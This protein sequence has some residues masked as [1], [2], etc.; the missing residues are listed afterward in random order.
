MT[1]R[2]KTRSLALAVACSALLLC[3]GLTSCSAR[4]GW[5]LVLWTAPAGPLAAGTIV[6]VY[7]KSNIEKLYVVGIPGSSKK[8]ELPLWQVELFPS[9]GKAAARL[10]ELGPNTSLYMVA[11]RDGLPIREDSTN[12]SRRVYRLREGQ[13]VK[14]LAKVTGEEV[15]TGGQVLPGDWYLVMADDGT[16]G[17]VFSYA[18]RI[19]DETKEGPPAVASSQD[20]ASA[21]VDLIFG[22]SWRPEYFQEMLDDQRVDLD[23]FSL[24]Y[25][26]FTDAVRHQIRI[27]LPT[28]SQVFN[29]DSVSQDGA[30]FIFEGTALRITIDNDRRIEASWTGD[31]AKV[32]DAT[33]PA[34]P[35]TGSPAAPPNASPKAPPVV[36]PVAQ[37]PAKSPKSGAGGAASVV[38][39]PS[40]TA[41]AS[42]ISVYSS[43]PGVDGHAVFV[44]LS[45]EPRDSIREEQVREQ[46]LLDAFMQRGAQ[47]FSPAA[48]KLSLFRSGGFTWSGKDQ[49]PAGFLPDGVGDTGQIA[50]RLFIDPRLT[51]W[52]G[53]FSLSFASG[54]GDAPQRSGWVN[55]VYRFTEQGLELQPASPPINGLTISGIDPQ[56]EPATLSAASR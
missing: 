4:L 23:L 50:F 16:R 11:I 17:Y 9:H 26:L 54:T 32:G 44:E 10:K 3:S 2:F 31:T 7:I 55:M 39:Q 5:G 34:G 48:G 25:G 21:R 15:S 35:V 24:R 53:A 14:I 51:D 37:P 45:V 8:L 27:E 13:S 30:T 52:E 40:M 22:Q 33:L 47:W 28:V 38:A 20:A 18:M 36:Q 29:Y 1:R 41:T 19:Y 42:A 43:P 49:L 56:F 6:P 46:R 12:N